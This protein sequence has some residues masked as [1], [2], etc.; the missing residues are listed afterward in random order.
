[1]VL[2]NFEDP[3]ANP[4]S[5]R[6]RSEPSYS[7]GNASAAG[8]GGTKIMMDWAAPKLTEAADALYKRAGQLRRSIQSNTE[9]IAKLQDV[10]SQD[11]TPAR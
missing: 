11:K 3:A 8:K 10:S 5:K 1:M 6:P 7:D 4:G 9:A 2:D